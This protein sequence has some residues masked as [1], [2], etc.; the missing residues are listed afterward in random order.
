M[1]IDFHLPATYDAD[2]I[3]VG[4][5]P[6]GA[7]TAYHLARCGFDVLM[8]DSA[9]FPRDK[10]CGDFVGPVALRELA[11]LGITTRTDFQ[12]TNKVVGASL[13]LD[14]KKMVT[15]NLP[16]VEGLPQFGRVIPRTNLDDWIL[17]AAIAAGA[18]FQ[19][20]TKVTRVETT[21]QYAVV[22]AATVGSTEGE[23]PIRLRA[24]LVVGAD[25]SN[26]KVAK[27][28][29]G[30]GR[31]DTKGRIVAVRA[32]YTDVAGPGDRCDM[33][34][35]QTSF[36]GYYW[37]FPT[38]ATT[39]N[40]GLG[41]VMETTPPTDGHLRTM[42]L[43]LVESDPALRA[44]LAG[45]TMEGR[46]LGWP[47]STYN[48]RA[49]LVRDGVILVG[50]A[51]G[52]IN[53]LNGEGI[54]YALLSGRWAAETI[55]PVLRAGSS[56]VSA[57]DLRPYEQRVASELRPEMALAT[58]IVSLI[59]RRDMNAVWLR[60]LRIICARATIDKQY[61]DLAGGILAGIT[62][63]STALSREILGGTVKQAAR[64]ALTQ[65]ARTAL[66]PRTQLRFM[67]DEVTETAGAVVANS[68]RDPM[69]SASWAS[70]VAMALFELAT[71]TLTSQL[72]LTDG[73]L[74][75]TTR[76]H[77]VRSTM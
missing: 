65:G 28:L 14:G 59:R 77:V 75:G 61:A 25:G 33:Y 27:A 19:A 21:D 32:Y 38:S 16:S 36:P 4:A 18:R 11:D 73:Q 69:A 48:H 49:P 54:Q 35:S 47:L 52:L 60:A 62:P 45:A 50:D 56:P 30:G 3:V 67:F 15:R 68:A 41:M 44:R 57:T 74:V 55:I 40:L 31:P 1:S 8:L 46:V 51:A 7:C 12:A 17:D 43:E 22:E 6:A 2:V 53:P 71:Q 42:L 66:R 63:A 9:A 39:A 34:F 26:S 5:G 72:P 37:L 23:E 10:V 20:K 24:R 13:Y 76:D 70:D 58:T 29:R 64:T